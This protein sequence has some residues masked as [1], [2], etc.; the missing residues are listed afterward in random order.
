M[1][2]LLYYRNQGLATDDQLAAAYGA[3]LGDEAQ[4]RQLVGGTPEQKKA[5]LDGLLH[6]PVNKGLDP[7]PSTSSAAA[8]RRNRPWPKL[9]VD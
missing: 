8:T 6:K 4:G 1:V 9:P 2:E 5:I 7:A 3:F